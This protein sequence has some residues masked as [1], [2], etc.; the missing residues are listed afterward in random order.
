MSMEQRKEGLHY[1]IGYSNNDDIRFHASSGGVGTAAIKYL[2]ES[3][4]CGT[5]ITYIYN[6]K[7]LKYEPKLI[8][9]FTDYNNCGSIYQDIDNLGFIKRNIN[10]IRDGIV[11]SCLP[12]QVKAIKSLL[13]KNN[14]NC[15]IIS[16]SC[17][18]CVTLEGCHKY[19]SAVGVKNLSE[20]ENVRYRGDGWPSGIKVILNNGNEIFH[21]NYSYPWS[22]LID[23][24]FYTPKRCMFCNRE[25]SYISDISLADP[26]LPY[27]KENEK[28]G[29]TLFFANTQKGTDLINELAE[30]QFITFSLSSYMDYSTAQAPNVLKQTSNQLYK[31]YNKF[32]SKLASN[33]LYRAVFAR[34]INGI[35]IH[36]FIIKRIQI[37]FSLTKYGEIIKKIKTKIQE[38]YRYLVWK[39]KFGSHNGF[40]YLGNKLEIINPQVIRLGN[41]VRI[42]SGT[43]LGPII[44]Y[45]DVYYNPTIEIGN[46]TIIGKNNSLAAINGVKIGNNVLFAGGV[47]I[48]DHSHGYED[49]RKPITH[50]VLISK[51][52]VIIEDDCW[53]GFN[54]EILSGV[55]I[56]KHSIVA[57]RAV[58]TKDVPP[59]SIVAGNPAK[60][61]KKYN[62]E[63]KFWEKI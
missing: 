25:T 57:A 5:A 18:G 44:H 54:C 21:D 4:K 33:K 36:N 17:S 59:F 13:N 7:E 10:N 50:Q 43:Y 35:K 2:L 8:Y 46:N 60:V 55:H 29:A 53:L 11:L 1:F 6:K 51:G 62:K 19:L 37:M 61:V 47:H 34:N 41:E 30:N 28:T 40:F 20:V 27:Y 31:H 9:D 56:G 58:V 39:N 45:A 52:P 15:F 63:T 16:F 24:K 42:G 38:K 12:C 48:T 3:G 32:L 49:I 26:W 23:S 22:I 14:I